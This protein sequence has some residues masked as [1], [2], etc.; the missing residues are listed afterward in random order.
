MGENRGVNELQSNMG[1]IA[2]IL[3]GACVLI[4][5]L[6]APDR[7]LSAPARALGVVIGTA[8]FVGGIVLANW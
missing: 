4:W 2:L 7:A 5:S 3:L 6:Y 8:M 1:G